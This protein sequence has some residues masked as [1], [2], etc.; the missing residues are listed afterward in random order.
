MRVDVS[1]MKIECAR[2]K[3]NYAIVGNYYVNI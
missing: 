2:M 1:G 3:N